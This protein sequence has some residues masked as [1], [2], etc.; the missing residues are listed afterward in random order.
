MVSDPYQTAANITDALRASGMNDWASK[1]DDI[2]FGG[3]TSSEILMGLRWALDDLL[4]LQ[5]LPFNLRNQVQELRD[6]VDE[7]LRQSI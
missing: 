6:T 2:V 3:S 4:T 5:S 7:L 1:I